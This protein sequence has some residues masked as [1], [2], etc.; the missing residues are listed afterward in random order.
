MEED[1]FDFFVNMPG[2]LRD[3]D[4]DDFGMLLTCLMFVARYLVFMM[5]IMQA[6]VIGPFLFTFLN[7]I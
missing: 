1:F 2:L 5:C 6:S 3:D 4:G 7:M